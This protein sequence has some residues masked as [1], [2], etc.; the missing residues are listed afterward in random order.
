MPSV[1]VDLLLKMLMLRTFG[2]VVPMN[3]R[4]DEKTY[5]WHLLNHFG[6]ILYV[7]VSWMFIERLEIRDR[8][9]ED[10]EAEN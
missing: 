8:E 3:I 9:K 10:S 5:S 4:V 1:R 6:N 7:S 2:I